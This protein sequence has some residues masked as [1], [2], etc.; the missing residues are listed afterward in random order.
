VGL[1]A[2]GPEWLGLILGGIVIGAAWGAVIGLIS[3]SFVGGRR[4]FTSNS[5]IVAARYD[6]A[7]EQ[8]WAARARELLD[9][10]G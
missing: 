7:V 8:G 3:Y 6:V 1:F 2:E 4:D 9:A 10:R 5:A